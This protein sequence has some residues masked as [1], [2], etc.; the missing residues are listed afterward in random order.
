VAIEHGALFNPPSA[1]VTRVVHT[2]ARRWA[3]RADDAEVAVSDFTLTRMAEQPHAARMRRIHNGVDLAE[4]PLDP[5]GARADDS[6]AGA[7]RVGFAGRL[8]PGKGA[9]VLIR[10]VARLQ[11]GARD[12]RAVVAGD[13]PERPRLIGLARELGVEGAVEFPGMLADLRALWAG[14]DLAAF[15]SDTFIDSF[16]MSALEA[17]ACGKPVVGTRSGGVPELVVDGVTGALVPP[18][19]VEALA[20]AFD[21]YAGS[22]SRVA[23]HGAAGRARAAEHFSIEACANAYLELFAESAR[24][25]GA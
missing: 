21:A 6:G 16:G 19:D 11:A 5:G 1:P 22:R 10:A 24:T 23:E 25:R 3:A 2:A 7:L 9:D 4:F 17:M 18:G 13:G 20:D 12:V 15:P 8:I 14:C